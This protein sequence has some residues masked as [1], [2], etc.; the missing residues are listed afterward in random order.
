[1]GGEGAPTILH[2]QHLMWNQKNVA[3]TVIQS[4]LPARCVLEPACLP[5]R[6]AY[7]DG[8]GQ[9]C[10][11]TPV[12]RHESAVGNV[13]AHVQPVIVDPPLDEGLAGP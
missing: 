6:A 12:R 13:C 11:T 9:R 3:H 7:A 2:S 10:T 4:P 1:M 5:H 8:H